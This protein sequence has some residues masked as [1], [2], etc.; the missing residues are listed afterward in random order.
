MKGLADWFTGGVL[1][2]YL[3]REA[4]FAAEGVQHR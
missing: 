4:P 3:G 2:A 1:I